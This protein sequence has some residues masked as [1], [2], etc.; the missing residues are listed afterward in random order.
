MKNIAIL[1]PITSNKRN[2]TTLKETDFYSYFLKTFFATYNAEHYYTLYLGIDKDDKLYN[3]EI[4]QDEIDRFIKIMKN[5]SV[6]MIFFDE[7]KY[8]G[9]PCWIWNEL[10]KNAVEENNDYYV[11]C[12]S[13]I[14]FI[15]KNW[16]NCA[17]DKLDCHNGLG[18]V[19][20][21]D[22]GR[23]ERNQQDNLLTQTMVTKKHYEI[24]GF[25]FPYNLPSWASDNW[26]GD[27]YYKSKLKFII[28]HRLY[29][30]GGEPRYT[31]PQDYIDNYKKSMIE[32]KYHIKKFISDNE[33]YSVYY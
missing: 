18:V 16:V 11:Q 21:T 29:N 23:K 32:Y 33:L 9:K 3:Q 5:T 12:G 30:L 10:F 2:W 24:F 6:K 14:S 4:I 8:K 20:L 26:I 19:G 31:V 15:D 28:P 1:I 22:Q 7:L 17:M 13:D 25:Y 27:L